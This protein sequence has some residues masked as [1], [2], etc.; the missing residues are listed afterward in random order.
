MGATLD[1]GRRIEL[2]SMDPHFRD[3]TIGLYEQTRNGVPEYV[4]HSYSGLDGTPQ[5][6]G[7]VAQAMEVLGGLELA[8]GHLRFSCGAR[9]YLAVRR[10]F[11]EAAKMAP[12]ATLAPRPLAIVDKKLDRIVTVTRLEPGVY[13]LSAA[14]PREAWASRVE[15]I[16]G[17]LRKL[18][19]LEFIAGEPYRVKFTSGQIHDSL[20]GLLMPRALNVRAVLRE[21]ETAASRGMLV[22]PSA[23]K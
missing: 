19:E 8:D 9:H 20:V 14:G 7:F 15:S 11:L 18:A 4:V 5:R 3:I 12:E 6:V 23:Q 2:V 10:V 16:A 21:E 17:G 13:E 1:L 22:A